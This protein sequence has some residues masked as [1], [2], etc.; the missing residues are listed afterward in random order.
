MGNDIRFQAVYSSETLVNLYKST[1]RY[2]P[3]D[4]HRQFHRCE[5]LRSQKQSDIYE[6]DY[7]NWNVVEFNFVK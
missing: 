2:N 4:Q 6:T 1:R 5:N 7:G 3:E